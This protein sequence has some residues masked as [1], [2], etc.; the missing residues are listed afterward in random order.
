MR[1]R[2]QPQQHEPFWPIDVMVGEGRFAGETS[3][4]RLQARITE[5]RYR[6]SDS[7]DEIVPLT[8]RAG[9]RW[10]VLAQ[11]YLLEPAISMRIGL[12]P[13]PRP[14]GAIGEVLSSEWE[15]MRHV[16]IGNAQAWLYQEDHTLI[17]W[18]AYLHGRWRQP[19]PVQDEALKTL[20]S[21]FERLL[22]ERL[23][24]VERIAVP[25]REP[26]YEGQKERWQAFLRELSYEPV[27]ERAFG[28]EVERP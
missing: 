20:W 11:P 14:D 6:H 10:Y 1:E 17:V 22:L 27:N 21:G 28:K 24:P 4:I 3:T 2:E 9:T 13:S 23:P 8:T 18:E 7:R 16:V 5:E 25:S 15:A 19:D 26:I 12:Y